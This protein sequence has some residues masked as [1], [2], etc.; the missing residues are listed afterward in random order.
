[1]CNLLHIERYTIRKAATS[2]SCFLLGC[3]NWKNC[4][5]ISSENDVA[6]IAA[7]ECIC[8]CVKCTYVK[9]AEL[10]M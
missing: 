5:L 7:Y 6:A 4:M 3:I 9:R 1:M 8:M 10:E 2:N